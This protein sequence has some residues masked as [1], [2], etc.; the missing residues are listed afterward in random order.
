MVCMAESVPPMSGT[1]RDM[2]TLRQLTRLN[3]FAA[4]ALTLIEAFVVNGDQHN[5]S[6]SLLSRRWRRRNLE[7]DATAVGTPVN[8]RAVE[9]TCGIPNDAAVR[10]STV[11]AA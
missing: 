7:N 1:L 2:G 10:K 3:V 8:R 9:I 5:R 6:Y 11:V 4:V